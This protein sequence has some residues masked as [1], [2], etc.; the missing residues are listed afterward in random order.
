MFLGWSEMP[1]IGDGIHFDADP[2]PRERTR[3]DDV[4]EEVAYAVDGD[5]D[6]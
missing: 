4:M 1:S 3:K 2:M 5:R 6:A